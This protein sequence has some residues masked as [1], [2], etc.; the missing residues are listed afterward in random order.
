MI[1]PKVNA[2]IVAVSKK[3]SISLIK[4]AYDLGLRNFGESYLQEAIEKINFLK[5]LD[6]TWH[7]IGRLQSNKIKK[8]AEN[9]DVVQSVDS[10]EHALKLDKAC[11]NLNK[12]IQILIQVNIGY[13][14]QK[15]GILPTDL[16]LVI[17]KIKL[18][19]NLE[20]KGLMCIPPVENSSDYFLEM[21]KIFDLYSFEILSMGMSS[22]Y[23]EAVRCGSNMVRIGS[24]IFGDRS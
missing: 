15:N 18:L 1:I 4:K 5:N 16:S 19:K 17:P 8:I 23:L 20:L 3:K 12:K 13:E 6:I 11:F 14:K 7:Y 22:D 21:K 24:L 2:K 9:F 10:Y